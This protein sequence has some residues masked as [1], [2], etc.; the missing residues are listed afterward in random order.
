VTI[1]FY[2]LSFISVVSMAPSADFVVRRADLGYVG[3]VR[4]A[5]ADSS[6]RSAPLCCI[7]GALPDA[8]TRR[9]AAD[10]RPTCVGSPVAAGLRSAG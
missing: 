8:A 4:G 2:N 6:V 10:G 3:I 1:S 9:N 5:S 7:P